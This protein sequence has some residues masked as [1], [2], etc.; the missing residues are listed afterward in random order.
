MFLGSGGGGGGEWGGCQFWYG[1]V[2]QENLGKRTLLEKVPTEERL[3][4][5]ASLITIIYYY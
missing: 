2:L 5:V 3:G 4:K 1:V